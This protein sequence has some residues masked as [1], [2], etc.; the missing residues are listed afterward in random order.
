MNVNPQP[1]LIDNDRDVRVGRKRE[2]R[3]IVIQVV[4]VDRAGHG[5]VPNRCA[6]I[7]N[8]NTTSHVQG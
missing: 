4:D 8:L 3:N 2:N 1:H 6:L 5:V 7:L